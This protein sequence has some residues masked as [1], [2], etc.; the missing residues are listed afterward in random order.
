M[1]KTI[2]AIQRGVKVAVAEIFPTCQPDH[3]TEGKGPWLL[4]AGLA[5]MFAYIT[6]LHSRINELEKRSR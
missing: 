4:V 3:L 1:N 5:G 6:R 2:T